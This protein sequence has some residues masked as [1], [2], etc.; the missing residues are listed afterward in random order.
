MRFGRMLK[1]TGFQ[2][3]KLQLAQDLA[4]GA[5]FSET[6]LAVDVPAPDLIA[7]VIDSDIAIADRGQG[8]VA[9]R[10][11]TGC[12]RDA[13]RCGSDF[14]MADGRLKRARLR[15]VSN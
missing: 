1:C 8:F 4:T 13:G 14:K 12:Y 2:N 7:K 15:S 3:F 9:G 11:G 6:R 5:H 10:T